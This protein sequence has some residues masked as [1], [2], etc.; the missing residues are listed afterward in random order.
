MSRRS[1]TQIFPASTLQ[2]KLNR[3][4][5]NLNPEY[6]RNSVW[7]KYNK[8]L[9]IDSIIIGVPI[10]KLFFHKTGDSTKWDVVDGQQRLRAIFDF[11]NDEFP[12]GSESDYEGNTY[13]ELP[14]TVKQTVSG[15]N[16]EVQQL[17]DWTPDEI[18][19]MF[20]RLQEGSALKAPEKRRAISGECRTVVKNLA[21]H[22]IF[23]IVEFNN[24]RYGWE[25]AI[26]KSL[27][28]H[29]YSEGA[30]QGRYTSISASALTKFYIE[31]DTLNNTNQFVVRLKKSMKILKDGFHGI[32]TNPSLKK[33]SFITL[34][35]V[36][37]HLDNEYEVAD[38]ATEL[39][40]SFLD[41]ESKRTENGRLDEDQQNTTLVRFSEY[42][43]NDQTASMEYR[44]KGLYENFLIKMPNLTPKNRDPQRQF[45]TSQRLAIWHLS[46]KK[47][48]VC[49]VELTQ[50]GFDADHIIK[51]SENGPTTVSNGRVLCPTCNRSNRHN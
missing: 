1:S 25:D 39:A 40:N 7:S 49:S 13:S 15:Y 8:Q 5:I 19:D 24:I 37:S 6:Q 31:N 10:P 16:L 47:C 26:A 20:L 4:E 22:N 41:F 14:E 11:L 23:A 9:L 44:H 28:Q 34:T 50:E 42:C 51:H 21:A 43:R 46:E 27:I 18:E 32:D 35:N 36:V 38:S 17:E 12:L 2:W 29:F 30:Y 33:W 3:E 48:S 45:S